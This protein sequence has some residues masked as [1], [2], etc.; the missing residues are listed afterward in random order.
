[1]CPWRN[2]DKDMAAFFPGATSYRT[3]ILALSSIRQKVLQHLGPGVRL[4][5]LAL[6]AHRVLRQ[7]KVVGTVVVRRAAGPHGA[8][9]A[10]VAVHTGG[11]VAGVRIQR[12]REP[13]VIATYIT[14][15][16]WLKSFEGET[17]NS[18]GLSARAPISPE[19]SE[20][21]GIVQRTVRS[22]LIELEEAERYYRGGRP[23]HH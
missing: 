8:I 17:A 15:P 9:E 6:D 23:Q 12:H 20:A 3:D 2:P 19:A 18:M 22:I 16:G 1:M 7:Q 5:S 4:E 14:S 13:A 10:V 11:K 21:A